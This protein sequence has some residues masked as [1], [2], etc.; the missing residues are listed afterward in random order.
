VLVHETASVHGSIT[1][2]QTGPDPLTQ[3]VGFAALAAVRETRRP[4]SSSGPWL[5][6][7][8]WESGPCFL[9]A[10]EICED[11]CHNQTRTNAASRHL[12]CIL[13]TAQE[14]AEAPNAE[15]R[16]LQEH[17]EAP[18]AAGC[19]LRSRSPRAALV[20]LT[21]ATAHISVDANTCRHGHVDACVNRKE[22]ARAMR[23][24]PRS[25]GISERTSHPTVF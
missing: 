10:L 8:L 1:P 11:A 4:N 21:P 23:T 18:I 24:Q 14:Q 22:L 16:M 3:A 9:R 20:A 13:R 7:S 15:H 2:K 19:H 25:N 5:S 12:R 17:A 6:I